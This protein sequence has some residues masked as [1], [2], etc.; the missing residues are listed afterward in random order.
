MWYYLK[1][2][3]KFDLYNKNCS[4][5]SQSLSNPLPFIKRARSDNVNHL[6]NAASNTLTPKK[7]KK[8]NKTDK[9]SVKKLGIIYHHDFR[10]F[11]N[12]A[13]AIH[14]LLKPHATFIRYVNSNPMTQN[15]G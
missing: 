6:I 8:K 5:L 15:R 11:V 10:C 4:K 1:T 3:N 2:K 13:G 7:C 9:S 12:I 14:K